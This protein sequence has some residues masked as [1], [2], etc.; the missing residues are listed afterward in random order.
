MQQTLEQR[1]HSH[2]SRGGSSAEG[3]EQIS[4][5]A[6][7][8]EGSDEE[9]EGQQLQLEQRQRRQKGVVSEGV[10]KTIKACLLTNFFR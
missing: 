7:G 2:Q 1:R 4:G 6:N 5:Q 9:Q 10:I 8:P 3:Q